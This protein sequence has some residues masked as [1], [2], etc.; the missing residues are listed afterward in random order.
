[1]VQTT[2]A[3]RLHE[4]NKLIEQGLYRQA[5]ETAA[6][7][8]E[9]LLEDLLNELLNNVS[10]QDVTFLTTTS[11]GKQ[12]N[13]AR[14]TLGEKVGFYDQ[15]NIFNRLQQTFGF[16]L[17]FLSV[18]FLKTICPLRNECVHDNLQPQVS[19]AGLIRQF[20]EVFLEET[21]HHPKLTGSFSALLQ[22]PVPP[23]Q[24]HKLVEREEAIDWLTTTEGD[25]LVIGE[26]GV[27]ITSLLVHF[28][29]DEGQGAWFVVGKDL[30]ALA[31]SI[32]EKQPKILILEDAD[33]D[34]D[35]LADLL[36]LRE[37]MGGDYC[38]IAT[39]GPSDSN[40]VRSILRSDGDSTYAAYVLRRLAQDHIVQV[41]NEIGITDNN[42][43][44]D[45]IVHQADGLPGLAVTLSHFALRGEEERIYTGEA[46]STTILQFNEQRIGGH[47]RGLLACF[48]LGG[49]SGMHRDVVSQTLNVAPLDLREMLVDLL[50]GGIVVEVP[51]II[52]R[53]KVRPPAL[54]HA[55]IREAFFVPPALLSQSIFNS[56]LGATPNL[57]DAIIELIATRARGGD[58]SGSLIQQNLT[59]LLPTEGK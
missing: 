53:F 59:R 21:Q 11:K 46:L 39:S 49:N 56:L 32:D 3:R 38:I 40:D 14:K 34:L 44:V 57:S 2:Y 9:I 24:E 52:D 51:N 54:R 19:Q 6:G 47:V 1:M 20:L 23:I 41:I 37:V 43:L 29:K 5:V 58:V 10:P 48:A 55:L 22:T 18:D 50:S 12:V 4:T 42:R 31:D 26:P 30:G 17:R 7:A 15:K 33:K 16:D 35:Y 28:A 13:F 45:E 36:Q 25:R 27:G 8:I